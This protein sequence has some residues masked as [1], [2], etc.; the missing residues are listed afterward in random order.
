MPVGIAAALQGNAA[1]RV[2]YVVSDGRCF[3]AQR[4]SIRVDDG[5]TFNA[6]LR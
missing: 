3:D 5:T 4:P 2:R 1:A 6:I